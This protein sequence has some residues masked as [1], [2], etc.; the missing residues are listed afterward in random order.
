[1]GLFPGILFRPPAFLEPLPSPILPPSLCISCWPP[2]SSLLTR[3]PAS[4]FSLPLFLALRLHPCSVL[5]IPWSQV[6]CHSPDPR[7]SPL[8]S[9]SPTMAS[10]LPVFQVAQTSGHICEWWPSAAHQAGIPARL[11]GH[12]RSS[13]TAVC[14]LPGPTSHWPAHRPGPAGPGP[15]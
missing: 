9:G 1:M 10:L 6:P 8:W 13:S 15:R 11:P 4:G 14:S 5:P 7:A 2:Y 12:D 3:S